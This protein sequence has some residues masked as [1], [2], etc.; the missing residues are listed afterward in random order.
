VVV[1][2]AVLLLLAARRFSPRAPVILAGG[3][4]VTLLALVVLLTSTAGLALLG[5]SETFSSRTRIWR[6]VGASIGE[7]PWLGHG[8]GAFWPSPAGI[9]T[10]ARAKKAINHAHNGFLDLTAELGAA[11]LVLVLVPLAVV[12]RAALRH[13]LEGERLCL[14][15]AAYLVY[16]IASNAAESGLLRHKLPWALYIAVAC[17]VTGRRASIGAREAEDSQSYGVEPSRTER[18]ARACTSKETPSGA[19]ITG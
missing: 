15:P 19:T 16:F 8:Y 17:H 12:G 5:R 6:A 9:R 3:A 14:W 11:G 10:L 4:V 1:L 18:S 2:I 13:A 7:M